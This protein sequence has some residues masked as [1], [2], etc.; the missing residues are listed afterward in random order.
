MD[1]HET[2]LEMKHWKKR[3]NLLTCKLHFS[4][5]QHFWY[6]CSTVPCFMFKMK[7]NTELCY[8]MLCYLFAY[9]SLCLV[10]IFT[11]LHSVAS[12]FAWWMKSEDS[13]TE[14]KTSFYAMDQQTIPR[15]QINRIQLYKIVA[16]NFS[17]FTTFQH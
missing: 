7:Y 13:S 10:F 6:I 1:G 4:C 15:K 3:E 11:H 2:K 16:L 14:V 8:A 9:S 12:C 17:L 5:T